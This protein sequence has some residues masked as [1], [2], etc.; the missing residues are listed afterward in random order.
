MGVGV[1]KNKAGFPWICAVALALTLLV[2]PAAAQAA[3]Y[4]EG[5]LG[6]VT[7]AT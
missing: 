7:G 6:G 5:Y 2:L 1:I 3:M 4:V